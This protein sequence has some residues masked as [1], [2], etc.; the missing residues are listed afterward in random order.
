MKWFLK[1][2]FEDDLDFIII[3]LIGLWLMTMSLILINI[4][5][6]SLFKEAIKYFFN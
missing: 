2:I 1:I 5:V 4:A 3:K 6:I